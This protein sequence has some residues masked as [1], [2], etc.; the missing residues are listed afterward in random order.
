MRSSG[1]TLPV[2]LSGIALI[3]IRACART[4]EVPV[5]QVAPQPTQTARVIPTAVVALCTIG[6]APVQ[7]AIRQ[8]SR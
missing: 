7:Q 8:R 1:P 3:L 5:A 4:A 2:L 6:D